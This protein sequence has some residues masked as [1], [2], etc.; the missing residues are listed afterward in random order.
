MQDEGCRGVGGLELS[1]IAHHIRKLRVRHNKISEA[2]NIP[3][4]FQTHE[5]YV[6]LLY[7]SLQQG[8]RQSSQA[9][10]ATLSLP[11]PTHSSRFIHQNRSI[12]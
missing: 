10:P 7:L 6:S 1:P 8:V 5:R 3:P 9:N 4:R 11:Y 12:S 2:V